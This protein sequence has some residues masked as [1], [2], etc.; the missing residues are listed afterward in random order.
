[1]LAYNRGF[2]HFSRAQ[3]VRE[4]RCPV[5]EEA[6][7][8]G[9]GEDYPWQAPAGLTPDGEP[10]PKGWDAPKPRLDPRKAPGKPGKKKKRS[11][12]NKALALADDFP[13]PPMG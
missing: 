1:M 3:F 12:R 2:Q 6:P 9:D 10:E 13:P 4:A 11:R 5:P 8:H 7:A